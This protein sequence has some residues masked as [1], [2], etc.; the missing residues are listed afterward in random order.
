VDFRFIFIAIF[1]CLT[2]GAQQSSGPTSKILTHDKLALKQLVTPEFQRLPL[3]RRIFVSYLADAIEA[4]RDIAWI[5]QGPYGLSIRHIFETM[6]ADPTKLYFGERIAMEHYYFRLLS[7]H[8]IYDRQTNEKFILEGIRPE[9]FA[10]ILLRYK[11]PKQPVSIWRAIFDKD[12]HRYAIAPRGRDPISESG[13]NFY[14]PGLNQLRLNSLAPE[15][16]RHSLSYPRWDSVLQKP[17]LAF[18]KLGGR[19]SEQLAKI[20][21]ALE[22]AEPWANEAEKKI[23]ELY[24]QV[25]RTGDPKDQDQLE[26]LWVENRTD[27]LV[28]HI[29]FTETYDDPIQ[30]R[31]TW[32]GFILLLNKDAESEKR[33]AQ[34]RA[35]AADFESRTPVSEEF[36]KAGEF[37]PTDAER[38]HLLYA[39]GGNSEA[40]FSSVT[41]GSR[42]FTAINNVF[43]I[44]QGAEQDYPSDDVDTFYRAEYHDLLRKFGQSL[45]YMVQIEF[46]EILGHGSGRDREGVDSKAALGGDYAAIEETRAELAA[47]YHLTDIGALEK[48]K[49]FPDDWDRKTI[50]EFSRTVLVQFFTRHILSLEKLKGATEIRHPNQLGRQIIFNQMLNRNA[51]GIYMTW[52]GMPQV[53][54]ADLAEVRRALGQV[55]RF[56]QRLK[57]TGNRDTVG[58]YI[59]EN[60]QLTEAQRGWLPVIAKAFATLKRPDH[61]LYIVPRIRRITNSKA[62]IVDVVQDYV[63]AGGRLD[64]L[65]EHEQK[66]RC[67]NLLL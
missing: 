4:G 36:K 11:I 46:Y 52:G 56:V 51:I 57:S 40:F 49:I 2:A 39:V 30:A 63:P 6:F 66:R 33:V 16:R 65:F 3:A 42:S 67:E 26:H 43:D 54:V 8:G 55:W 41:L 9:E 23:I 17:V 50:E 61:T 12:F 59:Q 48:H 47:L 18:H 20:D 60:G 37:T 64:K 29:G 34:I 35:S 27:D 7:S 1:F 5:Q 13:V 31:G 45:P 21:G 19:F 53:I 10:S 32:E 38:A 14:G 58:H 44:G 22:K 25:I 62:E 28:F 15:E 24:R